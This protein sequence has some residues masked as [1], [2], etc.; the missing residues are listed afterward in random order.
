M[1]EK[2]VETGRQSDRAQH[3]PSPLISYACTETPQPSAQQ[4]Y[5]LTRS[6]AL[7]EALCQL[8]EFSLD[9]VYEGRL[10]AC[11]EDA[12]LLATTAHTSLWVRDVLLLVDRQPLVYA[13]SVTPSIATAQGHGW[14]ALRAQGQQPLATVLYHDPCIQ[15]S[16]FEWQQVQ[17]PRALNDTH[18]ADKNSAPLWAR[19]SCF[20]RE[21]QPLVVA[22]TFLEAF[23]HHPGL[24]TLR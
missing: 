1:I 17:P 5:W 3:M 11:E 16:A 2:T 13:H 19:H 9:V 8:G 18:C 20:M 14:E 12:Q 15:R 10:E 7:T 24:A 23:W 6:G 22:E 21:T 4:H